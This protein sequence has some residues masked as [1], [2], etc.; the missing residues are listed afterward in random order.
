LQ[1]GVVQAELV[2][3]PDAAAAYDYFAGRY[4]DVVA[5]G[6]LGPSAGVIRPSLAQLRSR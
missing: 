3:G 6:W 1:R 5:V 4:G 2:G